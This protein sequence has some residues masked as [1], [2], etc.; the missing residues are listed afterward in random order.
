[1][2]FCHLDPLS[3]EYLALQLFPNEGDRIC[4]KFH[5]RYTESFPPFLITGGEFVE[6]ITS[7]TQ[8]DRFQEFER[9]EVC[10]PLPG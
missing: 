5:R 7:Q 4:L 2:S 8:I 6:R 1:M 3:A 10:A 9:E